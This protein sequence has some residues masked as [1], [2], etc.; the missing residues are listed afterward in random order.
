MPFTIGGE[1]YDDEEI[2]GEHIHDYNFE[3]DDEYNDDF[4]DPC[5]TDL[6]D[7]FEFRLALSA[8]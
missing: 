8:C 4:E 6:V 7:K 5:F 1:L 2:L 3:E